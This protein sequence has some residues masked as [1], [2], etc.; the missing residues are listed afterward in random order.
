MC[1]HGP[2][3]Q[4]LGAW[5]ED[6]EGEWKRGVTAMD[7]N[8][9]DGNGD[10]DSNDGDI[11]DRCYVLDF[12]LNGIKPSKIWVQADYIRIY[13][14]LENW[15]NDKPMEKAPSASVIGQPGI[16]ECSSIAGESR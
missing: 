2:P 16:G 3:H 11:G 7:V 8:K 10:S 14:E 9:S 13:D 15:L 1:F 6:H 5:Q 4:V 12:G